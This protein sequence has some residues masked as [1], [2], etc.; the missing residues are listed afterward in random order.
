MELVR[1][2]QH[3]NNGTFDNLREVEVDTVIYRTRKP[4]ELL[5]DALIELSLRVILVYY[6]KATLNSQMSVACLP[7]QRKLDCNI[8][9]LGVH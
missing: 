9:N 8:Y 3:Y 5:R 2:F 6:K 4:L 1:L 7:K